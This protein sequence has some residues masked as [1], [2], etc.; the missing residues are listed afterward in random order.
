MILSKPL[1]IFLD[2]FF[3]NFFSQMVFL[4]ISIIELC[5]AS[6]H[7]YIPGC[8][9]D[10]P[11]AVRIHQVHLRTVSHMPA[12]LKMFLHLI[13]SCLDDQAKQLAPSCLVALALQ[14]VSR[15]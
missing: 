11:N 7:L 5:F 13:L 4:A 1:A 14:F 3:F 8:K 15:T 9:L 6:I 2:G 10:H 12:I